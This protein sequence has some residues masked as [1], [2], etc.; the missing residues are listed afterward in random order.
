MAFAARVDADVAFIEGSKVCIS[1]QICLLNNF[2]FLA[3][4]RIIDIPHRRLHQIERLSVVRRKGKTV[5]YPIYD[6]GLVN[7]SASVERTRA[8]CIER[9]FDMKNRPNATRSPV[10]SARFTAES[11]RNPP[12][13]II[14]IGFAISRTKS[15]SSSRRISWSCLSFW[16]FILGSTT[17]IYA[18]LGCCFL[19][20]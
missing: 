5:P 6:V 16:P 15:F 17:W 3:I 7:V 9:T 10:S 1:L 20:S 19:I 13:V 4:E 14:G 18:K 12:A 2:C 8:G 11:A